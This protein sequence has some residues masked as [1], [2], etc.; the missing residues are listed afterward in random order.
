MPSKDSVVMADNPTPQDREMYR[1]LAN[2][3][4]RRMAGRR[5]AD[6]SDPD[7]EQTGFY[8]AIIDRADQADAQAQAGT[9]G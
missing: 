8:R 3:A 2:L 1:G 9:R 4:E 7:D 6:G 5:R